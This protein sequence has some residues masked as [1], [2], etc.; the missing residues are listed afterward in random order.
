MLTVSIDD[1]HQPVEPYLKQLGL[2]AHGG[3]YWSGACGWRSPAAQRFVVF[4][5]PYAVLI[6]PNGVIVWRGYP[7]GFVV[8]LLSKPMQRV[9]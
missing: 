8:A 6:D 9:K 1:T 7:A 3:H 2:W 5:I 4:S